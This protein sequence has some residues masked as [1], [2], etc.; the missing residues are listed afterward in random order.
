MNRFTSG[1][2]VVLVLSAAS[3][4]ALAA[5]EAPRAAAPV[6]A[7]AATQSTTTAAKAVPTRASA[8]PAAV[9]DA[10]V[11]RLVCLNMSLQCFALKPKTDDAAAKTQ[12]AS[13]DLKAPDIRRIVP[14]VELRAPL[15]EPTEIEEQQ[16][17][18]EGTR[19]EVYVPGG[20]A[21]LPWAVMHP[22]QAWRIFLPVPPG[23]AK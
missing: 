4:A 1:V 12:T 6:A 19:P 13:L 20:I 8:T 3:F 14:E 10:S 16:V 7:T 9:N 23:T 18:V 15:Q 2:P 11:R 17:Q 21:S 5:D 22:T